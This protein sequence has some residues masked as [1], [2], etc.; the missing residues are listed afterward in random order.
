M[1]WVST[2]FKFRCH[3]TILLA[4]P[5]SLTVDKASLFIKYMKNVL[6]LKRM[7]SIEFPSQ[8]LLPFSIIYTSL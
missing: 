4:G 7:H 1:H 2:T 6:Y 3:F 8:F 5:N